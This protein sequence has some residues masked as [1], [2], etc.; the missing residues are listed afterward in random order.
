MDVTTWKHSERI[1]L[2]KLLKAKGLADHIRVLNRETSL[3]ER[4]IASVCPKTRGEHIRYSD[5][6][7]ALEGSR[8]QGEALNEESCIIS[9][10][11]KT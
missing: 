11:V 10:R 4:E 6:Y 2:R 7:S 5:L 1:K 3:G 9:L 8:W